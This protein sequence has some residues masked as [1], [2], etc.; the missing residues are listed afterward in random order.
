VQK[1]AFSSS[2]CT[3][4]FCPTLHRSVCSC[5]IG[6]EYDILHRLRY[7]LGVSNTVVLVCFF[8]C[9][10]CLHCVFMSLN[11]AWL[12]LVQTYGQ[13]RSFIECTDYRRMVQTLYR[14][15]D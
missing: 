14:S 13:A 9:P 15:R 6:Q 1:H 3:E 5:Q 8:H 7:P 2:E 12:F 4:S 11:F 10:V